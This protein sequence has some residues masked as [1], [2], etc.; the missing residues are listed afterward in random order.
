MPLYVDSEGMI[1]QITFDKP[2]Q[3][4]EH[5]IEAPWWEKVMSFVLRMFM[6]YK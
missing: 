3:V 6:G 1:K 5:E 2:V 4:A